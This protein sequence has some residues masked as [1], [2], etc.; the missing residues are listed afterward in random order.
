MNVEVLIRQ[1]T[2]HTCVRTY[3]AEAL[4]GFPSLTAF[5]ETPTFMDSLAPRWRDIGSC[6]LAASRPSRGLKWA[7]VGLRLRLTTSIRFVN[8]G[9][10]S[11]LSRTDLSRANSN[12]VRIE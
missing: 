2:V 9:N 4:K 7:T 3:A 8:D 1:A 12:R 11:S 6:R 5:R 10:F